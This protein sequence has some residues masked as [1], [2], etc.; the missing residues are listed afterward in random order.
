[1]ASRLFIKLF[2]DAVVV[3]DTDDVIINE[4]G[5][6]SSDKVSCMDE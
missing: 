5:R 4:L 3:V 6:P 1:M 2:F